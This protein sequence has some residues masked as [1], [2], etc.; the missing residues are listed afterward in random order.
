MIQLL[1][2]DEVKTGP[3]R[4]Q[5]ERQSVS[6]DLAIEETRLVNSVNTLREEE[7]TEKE[8]IAKDVADFR[9]SAKVEI[10]QLDITITN[11]KKEVEEIEDRRAEA[12]KPIEAV[13]KEADDRN[14]ASKELE[15]AVAAKETAQTEAGE[16]LT[17]RTE[18]ANDRDQEQNEREQGLEQRETNLRASEETSGA[19]ARAL[20]EKWATFHLAVHAKNDDFEKREAVV[21]AGGK[22]NERRTDEIGKRQVE[23]DAKDRE[24]IDKYATLERSRKEILEGKRDQTTYG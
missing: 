19:S 1:T 15:E 6:R 23:Q 2:P 9:S 10:C 5:Q 7:R 18:A 21:A 3:V 22:A 20:S 14:E 16:E 8:R 17:E 4:A 12:M 13:R 24:I 11:R